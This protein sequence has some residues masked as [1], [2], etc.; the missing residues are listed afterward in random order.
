LR[1]TAN[2]LLLAEGESPNVV[3][4]RMG[5]SSTRMTLDLY[6]HVMPGAQKSAAEKMDRIF[7]SNSKSE[8]G[9]QMGVKL[10]DNVVELE[11]R[12][13]RKA[14]RNAGLRELE[15]RGLEPL[16]PYMR[17]KKSA[18]PRARKKPKK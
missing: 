18:K 4:E 3:A 10:P 13:T 11:E 15:M 5:H 1:H 7:D 8:L 6:G 14:L 2:S 9:G 16:T 12:K 17:S